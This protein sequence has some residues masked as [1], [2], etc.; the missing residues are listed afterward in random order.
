MM[1]SNLSSPQQYQ[2]TL[3][4]NSILSTFNQSNQ[5]HKQQNNQRNQI[6][7]TTILID[8]ASRKCKNFIRLFSTH[9]IEQDENIKNSKIYHFNLEYAV[10][11]GNVTLDIDLS[12]VRIYDSDLYDWCITYPSEMIPIFDQQV[13][14]IAMD[15]FNAHSQRSIKCRLYNAPSFLLRHIPPTVIEHLIQIQGFVVRVGELIPDLYKACFKCQ[16]CGLLMDSIVEKMHL[17]EPSRC[18]KC[19]SKQVS[20]DHTLSQYTGKQLIRIQEAPESIPAGQTPVSTLCAVYYE[21]LDVMQPGDRVIVTGI[22]RSIANRTTARKRSY[23]RTT[24]TVVEVVHVR[25]DESKITSTRDSNSTST[26]DLMTSNKLS[27]NELSA[28]LALGKRSD[29]YELLV[30]SLAPAIFDLDNAKKGVLLQL[31]G[32]VY[33]EATKTRGDIHILLVG[34]PGVSKSQL[35]K[36][37]QEIA[38]RSIYTSGKGSS[39]VGL[40]A[41]VVKDPD[42]NAYVLESGA[43]VMSDGG[44][45]CLDEFDKASHMARAILHEVME[46]QTVSIAKAGIV[47]SL[48]ARTSILA[49]A[50]PIHSRFDVNLS[51]PEN[52]NLAPSL[53]SRFDLVYVMLDHSNE[54]SDARLAKRLAS[55]CITNGDDPIIT[56]T[57]IDTRTFTNYIS[58]AKELAPI[59]TEEASEHVCQCFVEMRNLGRKYNKE[60]KHVSATMRQMMSMMRLAEAHA[61]VHLKTTVD[62]DDVQEAYRLIKVALQQSAT[63][64]KTGR[65]NMDLLNTGYTAPSGDEDHL[66]DALMDYM[67]KSGVGS[68]G[69]KDLYRVMKM[70]SELSRSEFD[71]VL[72]VLDVNQR[73]HWDK[74]SNLIKLLR[75]E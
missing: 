55:L 30:R 18:D 65:I 2:A 24:K 35:L 8:E 72:N 14:Q 57:L 64:P 48:R 19:Q 29:I 25:H 68:F 71:L 74:S 17:L 70:N 28:V 41:S 5:I 39:A 62:I 15:E 59:F 4:E 21:H 49:A 63:D 60:N 37:V 44:I 54:K 16:E 20:L 50:N 12:H 13:T 32:G 22:L 69:Y 56:D 40:T 7:G 23:N 73:I 43:L 58:Y 3:Q 11:S 38:P 34:D 10:T 67:T 6:W 9:H 51:V 1:T 75:D 33:Q 26:R 45:C 66:S 53:L 47:T 46:Q 36:A 42:T 52:I 31:M 27:K 61:K